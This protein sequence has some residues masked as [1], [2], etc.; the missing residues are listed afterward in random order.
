MTRTRTVS[1]TVA[2]CL[3]SML[4]LNSVAGAAEPAQPSTEPVEL[5]RLACDTLAEVSHDEAA[6][7]TEAVADAI[8][9][10]DV[11][12]HASARLLDLDDS[13]V[14]AI[15]AEEGSTFT[16]VAVPITDGYDPTTKLTVLFDEGGNIVEYLETHVRENEAGNF[17]VTSYADGE[18]AKSQDTG[19]EFSTEAELQR[20]VVS[21]PG[22]VAQT[23][24]SS[25][26]ACLAAV[27]GVSGAFAAIIASMCKGAC[28]LAAVG[29]G[30][31]FCLACVGGFVSLGG[32]SITQV[33]SCFS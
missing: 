15:D 29:I 24:S 3:V 1:T 12:I 8:Q 25:T 23:Q 11:I 30:V 4:A 7:K 32:V 28:A 10:G 2:F 26:A 19:I 27:L 9:R 6:A 18:V 21:A 16:L 5:D 20:E 13:S 22:G 33:G 31:P 14:Y 17:Q